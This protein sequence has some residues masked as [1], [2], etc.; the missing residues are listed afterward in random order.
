MMVRMKAG[1]IK[2]KRGQTAGL[3]PP[4][5]VR[6]QTSKV[7][8]PSGGASSHHKVQDQR[9]HREDEQQ[10]N[11]PSGHVE[12]RKP[13]NPCDQQY[14]EQNCPDAHFLLLD[15]RSKISRQTP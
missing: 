4:G 13:G 2:S 10:V 5:T 14:H 12:D 15:S 7:V 3:A 6:C 11:Q 8:A 1:G 9:N